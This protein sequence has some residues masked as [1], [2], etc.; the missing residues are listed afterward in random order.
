MLM[1]NL[2]DVRKD[3]EKYAYCEIIYNLTETGC[4]RYNQSYRYVYEL[5]Q[6]HSDKYRIP[7]NCYEVLYDWDDFG[8]GDGSDVVCFYKDDEGYLAKNPKAKEIYG[9]PDEEE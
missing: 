6:Q 3:L 4:E 8:V 9:Q 7:Y 5:L 2:G 1:I